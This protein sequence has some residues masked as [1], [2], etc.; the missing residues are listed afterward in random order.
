M[1]SLK[2]SHCHVVA[3]SS[4]KFNIVNEAFVIIG[5]CQEKG[6]ISNEDAY[7]Y[8]VDLSY[9][10]TVSELR[11]KWIQAGFD[12]EIL[13]DKVRQ[14]K[15]SFGKSASLGNN[16][17]VPGWDIEELITGTLNNENQNR[18]MKPEEQLARLVI[19]ACLENKLIDNAEANYY[20]LLASTKPEAVKKALESKF[21]KTPK[22][23]DSR[24]SWTLTD[25]QKKDPKGL[26]EMR[27]NNPEAYQELLHKFRKHLKAI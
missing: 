8:Q 11:N 14:A 3:I 4:K 19:E 2:D 23:E 17:I 21:L 5:L 16:T 15:E 22:M 7:E 27:A 25:W 13:E 10:K 12:I 26:G 24:D 20:K 6:L 9:K 18:D 1:S